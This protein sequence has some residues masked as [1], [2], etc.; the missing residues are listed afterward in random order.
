MPEGTV[1]FLFS[2]VEGS[3]RM[4]EAHGRAVGSA[5]VRHHEI[6]DRIVTAHRGV[7]FETVGDAVYAAFASPADAVVTAVEAHRAL[8]TEH[9]EE[10]GGRL[11]CRIAIHTGHVVRR[12]NRYFGTPLFRCARLEA[13]AHGEQTV[14]SSTTAALIGHD[15]PVDVHLVDR[16]AH[17]LKDLQEPEHVFEV[18]YAGGRTEFPPLRSLDARRHNLPVQLSTFVGREGEITAAGRSVVEHRLVTLLGPGGVGKTRLALQAAAGAIDEFADGAWFVDLAATR[19][20]GQ[21]AD[22]IASALQIRREGN[23]PAGDLLRL[24]MSEREL[25]LILDNLE[26]LLPEAAAVV[27][28]LVGDLPRVHVL[29]TSRTPLRIRGE[30]EHEVEPLPA[31]DS[32]SFE[33]TLPPAVALFLARAQDIGHDIAID[34]V[35]GPLVASICNRL[36]GLPL[37]IELAAA[38]LRLLSLAALDT[39]LTARLPVL[40][41]GA[42][43]LPERQQTLRAAIAWSDEILGPHERALFHRLG[44][45]AGDFDL[46]AALVAS[47]DDSEAEIE[48]DLTALLEQSLIR[49]RDDGNDVRFSMLP[50]IREYAREEL[51]A[52]NRY[53]ET[54]SRISDH[55]CELTEG[56]QEQMIGSGQDAAMARLDNELPNIRLALEWLLKEREGVRL[57]RLVTSLPRY[58]ITR[59]LAREAAIWLRAATDLIGDAPPDL[60]AAMHMADAILLSSTEPARAIDAYHAAAA[61]YEAAGDRRQVARALIGTSN[62]EMI[63]G[64]LDAGHET[65]SRA[66]AIATEVRDVRAQASATGN[67]AS[68]AMRLGRMEEGEAG[69]RR[70]INLFEQA[71]DLQAV[72]IGLGNL[73]EAAAWRGEFAQAVTE[74][75]RALEAARKHRDVGLE[76]WELSNLA[77]ALKGMGEWR[78]AV[79]LMLEGLIK[80]HEANDV[81]A[82][83]DGIVAAGALLYTAGD[84]DGAAL[85][86]AVGLRLAKSLQLSLQ[87]SEPGPDLVDVRESLG[88]AYASI[89]AEAEQ[90]SLGAAVDAVT[91]RLRSVSRDT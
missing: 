41:G 39:R 72:V 69:M 16:G 36:D 19:D 27:R 56:L 1:T 88:R 37:A 74:H 43:D 22:Q 34:D 3:T 63:I 25:V 18:Q 91:S 2:D 53:D 33:R 47:G 83:P 50:T 12:G 67:M 89:V 28:D 62:A 71:G 49:R 81:A 26:Q 13:L 15:L 64:K 61:I 40:V 59:G 57:A 7:V 87:V 24:Q 75:R 78:D 51:V 11:A 55:L 17:R 23:T 9:W 38:R 66:L 48:N 77:T 79:P 8:A 82:L 68:A 54:M 10:I 90:L 46:D 70:A 20:A 65:A 86:W 80:L 21:I 14:V 6:F 5:M 45:F 42:R 73:G 29:V 31:V 35:S 60:Q 58:W 30:V 84:M 85:A 4:L 52:E 32:G 76:G 44:A